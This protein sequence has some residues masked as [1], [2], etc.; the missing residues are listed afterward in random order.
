MTNKTKK[1]V[2]LISG[3]GSNLQAII[4]RLHL[5]TFDT[6]LFEIVKVISNISDAY[7]LERARLADISR[8]CIL[9]KGA[10]SREAYDQLL[11]AS[12]DEVDADV[13]VLAGFMRIL[14]SDFVEKYKGKLLNIHPSLLPKYTGLDT[15]Q[16]AIDAKDEEHGTSVHF[17]IADLDA[18]PVIVQAKVPVFS[19]DNASD[20]ADRVLTQEHLIYPMAIQWL[21]TNRLKIQSGKA[22]LDGELLPENGYA[23]D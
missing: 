23:A 5:K 2:V 21:L 11:M 4:D 15:H 3:N 9:S 18:G 20:L 7:G 14:S 12:I 17:V 13:I 1:I 10:S 19:D 22:I 6:D 16:R 8:Q